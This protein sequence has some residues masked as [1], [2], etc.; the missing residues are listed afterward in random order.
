M[1]E[2]MLDMNVPM[3]LSSFAKI[4]NK[5]VVF[6]AMSLNSSIEDVALEIATLSENAI[7]AISTMNDYLK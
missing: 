2:I 3:P 7:D 5:Y 4:E 6:G 1:M